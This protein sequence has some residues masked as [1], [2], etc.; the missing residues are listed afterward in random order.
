[1][2]NIQK[3]TDMKQ[4]QTQGTKGPKPTVTRSQMG[5]TYR[6]GHK[7]RQKR[8]RESSNE[9]NNQAD[10]KRDRSKEQQGQGRL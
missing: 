4:R 8:N 7:K 2:G 5:I 9:G 6:Q 1:M 3:N 10:I